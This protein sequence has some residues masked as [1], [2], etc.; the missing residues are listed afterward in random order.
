MEQ[1]DC[2]M[3]CA[4][5]SNGNHTECSEVCCDCE[6]LFIDEEEVKEIEKHNEKEKN[7]LDYMNYDNP[8]YN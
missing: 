2:K 7:D 4:E 6:C 3:V 1:G 5:C 8:A